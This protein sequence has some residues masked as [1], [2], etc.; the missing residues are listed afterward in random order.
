MDCMPLLFVI[1]LFIVILKFYYCYSLIFG[2]FLFVVVF[3]VP[4]VAFS[5]FDWFIDFIG[6]P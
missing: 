4:C 3:N 6:A 5:S 1:H 2:I